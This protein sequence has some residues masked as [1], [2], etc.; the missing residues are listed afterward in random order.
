[1]VLRVNLYFNSRDLND[2]VE[3]WLLS[4][5]AYRRG[6]LIKRHIYQLAAAGKLTSSAKQ[7]P[8]PERAIN[9]PIARVA[10]ASTGSRG[11]ASP[12]PTIDFD[13]INKIM[14]RVTRKR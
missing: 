11:S 6:P 8:A 12:S 5:P 9:G 13:Q 10:R 14:T 7:H 4:L 3:R 2:P 1:M